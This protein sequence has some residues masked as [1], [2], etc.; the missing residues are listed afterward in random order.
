MADP[1]F[2]AFLDGKPAAYTLQQQ[3]EFG[4]RI[5]RFWHTSVVVQGKP[6]WLGSV[7]EQ[8]RLTKWKTVDVYHQVP[9]VD[10]AVDHLKEALPGVQTRTI[11]GF[12]NRGLYNWKNPFF[13]HGTALELSI[14]QQH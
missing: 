8:Q 12:R 7:V 3:T 9:D 1:V 13:T 6:V 14:P 5:I 4:R 10:L 2:P 11:T